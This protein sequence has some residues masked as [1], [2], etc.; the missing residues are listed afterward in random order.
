[1]AAAGCSL[2]LIVLLGLAS[3]GPLPGGTPVLPSVR[4]GGGAGACSLSMYA[5]ARLRSRADLRSSVRADYRL[6]GQARA[7]PGL[8]LRGGNTPDSQP[9]STASGEM[10]LADGSDA[11][12]AHSEASDG[13]VAIEEDDPIGHV[14][15]DA[16]A[17]CPGT[18][19]AEAGKSSS[20]EGCPNQAKCASGKGAELDPDF[21]SIQDRMASVDYKVLVLS[22]KG[23]VGKSTVASQ[24][25]MIL[26]NGA[27]SAENGA[28][29]LLDIDICGPSVPRMMGV[30][31]SEVR[32]AA[33]GWQPVWV[34]DRLCVMSIGFMLPSRED[35]V[36][37]RGVRKNGLM[38]QFLK[39]VEWGSLDYLVVDAPPGTSDEHITIAQCLNQTHNV[40]A[41][42]VTTPQEIAL[43]D[44]RKEINFCAKAGITVVGIVENMAGFVCP[45]CNCSSE[46]FPPSRTD[47]RLGALSAEQ[48]NAA[49]PA[50]EAPSGAEGMARRFAIPFLGRVALDPR[51]GQASEKGVCLGA[52]DSPAAHALHAVADRVRERL[53]AVFGPPPNAAARART[54][55]ADGA[56]MAAP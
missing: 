3:G 17:A 33:S 27:S 26:S 18:Q 6:R 44:V 12:G 28:T 41:V 46:I 49:G 10:A 25:A 47:S 56:S 40:G 37:W 32:Q 20:C 5:G 43:L 45:H 11:E 9:C 55:A 42:I 13:E 4:L 38:K 24:L 52:H 36:V 7:V 15:D 30:E 23:G 31:A 54:A 29:G 53:R 1:M 21:A 34:N 14:P 2:L 50:G 16:P 51:L 22:G 39:D 48:G 8:R 35:A 19:A